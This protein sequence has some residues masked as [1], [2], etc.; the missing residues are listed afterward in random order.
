MNRGA[1]IFASMSLAIGAAGLIATVGPFYAS[2]GAS[3]MIV[4]A[5]LI[6]PKR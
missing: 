5:V 1:W 4:L 3:A 6:W 2:V